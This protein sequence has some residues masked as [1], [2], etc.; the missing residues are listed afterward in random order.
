M[1]VCE[2]RYMYVCMY[3]CIEGIDAWHDGEEKKG[4]LFGGARAC[5]FVWLVFDFA[6]R[7]IKE[8]SYCV[9]DCW[10]SVQEKTQE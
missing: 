9:V 6:C 4:R 2:V 1:Y 10:E 3:V 7:F 5:G 8:E